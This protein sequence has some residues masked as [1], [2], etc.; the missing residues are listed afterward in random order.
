PAVRDCCVVGV[1]SADL[2]EEPAAFV[3]LREGFSSAVE[4]AL[5]TALA[6]S[7]SASHVPRQWRFV[8]ELPRN[9]LGKIMRNL[10]RQTR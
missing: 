3:V 4:E 1:P 8:E 5:R 2:G 7:L 6:G 10:L 9:A